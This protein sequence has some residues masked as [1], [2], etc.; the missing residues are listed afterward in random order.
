[1]WHFSLEKIITLLL[2]RT[3]F[4][5]LEQ[6]Y[7]NYCW[8][9]CHSAS[10][11]STLSESL[12]NPRIFGTTNR[13]TVAIV[14]R[15]S[16]SSVNRVVV[17]GKGGNL[18]QVLLIQRAPNK[19]DPWSA[20]IAFPGGWRDE[21]DESDLDT[22]CREAHEELGLDLKDSKTYTLLGRL[23]DRQFKHLRTKKC[24]TLS[25]FV[26]YLCPKAPRISFS[27]QTTEVASAFWVSL[28]YLHAAAPTVCTHFVSRTPTLRPMHPL[29]LSRLS[30][31]IRS[32]LGL[33]TLA[34]PAV[35]V[36]TV[37]DDIV[38]S[39]NMSPPPA[40]LWGLTLSCIG[41]LVASLG[42]RRVDWPPVL[43]SIPLLRFFAYIVAELYWFISLSF[44]HFRR[45]I[46][47]A[48]TYV[49]THRPN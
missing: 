33:D 22:A 2:S 46:R 43:P 42:F 39:P 9:M 16:P 47:R 48:K 24:A 34:M 27:L 13:A 38:T 35:D 11:I 15:D 8:T 7:S 1:M 17:E 28:A 6:I 49:Q 36:L 21:A 31:A 25:A 12:C 5:E 29:S 40:F 10:F 19:N 18:P 41:D 4:F 37:V 14:L 23:N 32:I 44:T 3:A 26:F 20:H 45:S 30:R